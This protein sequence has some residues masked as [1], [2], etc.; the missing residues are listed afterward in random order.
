MNMDVA[1][2]GFLKADGHRQRILEMLG[3]RSTATAQQASHRLRMQPR[4]T[5]AILKDL[6]EKGLVKEDK[7]KYLLTDE[8]IKVLTQVSRAGM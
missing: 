3:K 7:G 5:E 8:G 6:I 2:I 1:T 4:Q